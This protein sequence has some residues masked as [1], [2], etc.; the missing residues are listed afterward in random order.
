MKL[1]TGNSNTPLAQAIAD[2]AAWHGTPAVRITRTQP[3]GLKAALGRAVKHKT[4]SV[5]TE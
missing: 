1:I 2:C 4:E 3:A 5:A